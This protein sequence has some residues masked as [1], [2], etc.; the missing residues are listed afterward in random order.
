[1]HNR[2]ELW[3]KW[4]LLISLTCYVFVDILHYFSFRINYVYESSILTEYAFESTI[5]SLLKW[6]FSLVMIFCVLAIYKKPA[7]SL[8]FLLTSISGLIALNLT[9]KRFSTIISGSF[10]YNF[11]ILEL[12]T[13]IAMLLCLHYIKKF[14]FSLIYLFIYLII[15]ISI[16]RLL[17]KSIPVINVNPNLF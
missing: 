11:F 8:F 4:V 15:I 7:V 2:I 5:R 3:L 9:S 10:V 12:A 17:F 14:K 1:M 6:I 16:F 13:L